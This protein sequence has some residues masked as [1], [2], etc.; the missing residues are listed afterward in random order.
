MTEIPL[1][2]PPAAPAKP[3]TRW[4]FVLVGILALILVI[5][6]AGTTLFFTRTWPPLAATYDFTDDLRDGDVDA[7]FAQVC[8]RLQT[9]SSRDGLETFARHVAAADSLGVNILS[10]DRHDNAASVDFTLHFGSD[11]ENADLTL[12][13][14]HE[15]G[16]WKPCGIT[17]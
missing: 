8:E 17:R 7:A 14:V 12:H 16:D 3:R 2:P 1:P 6:L 15:D 4:I 11:D 13:L 5:T 10:V 9:R